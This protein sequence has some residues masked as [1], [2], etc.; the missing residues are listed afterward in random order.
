M[1]NPSDSSSSLPTTVKQVANALRLGGWACFWIQ[2]VLGVISGLIFL[3]TV[4]T[5]P[6]NKNQAGTASTGSGLFFAI[7]GLLVLGFSIYL[8]FCYTRLARKLRSPTPSLR[9]T[10]AD[11]TKQV[12]KTLI[13]NLIGMSLT[14]IGAEAIGGILLGKSLVSGQLGFSPTLELGKIIQP[15]DIF[16]VLGNT[17]MI[18]AHF[19]GIVVGLFLLDRVYK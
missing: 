3:F 9:P 5:L 8:A 17:H 14:L 4:F 19:V 2:L 11:T 15:L 16:I 13:A 12:K 18:V 1:S 7:C 10:R 6:S